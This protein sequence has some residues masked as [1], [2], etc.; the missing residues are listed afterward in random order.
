VIRLDEEDGEFL[1]RVRSLVS[2]P[3]AA[4]MYLALIGGDQIA[5]VVADWTP[6]ARWH[7]IARSSAFLHIATAHPELQFVGVLTDKEEGIIA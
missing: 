6:S 2:R 7:A 5:E 4:R 1:I 3:G